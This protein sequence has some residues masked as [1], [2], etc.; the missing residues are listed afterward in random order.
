MSYG[1]GG[2][3]GRGQ[4]LGHTFRQ[5][6]SRRKGLNGHGV[7][8]ESGTYIPHGEGLHR[9]NPFPEDTL[10]RPVCVECQDRI[11]Y[12]NGVWW[13]AE[14]ENDRHHEAEPKEHP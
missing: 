9:N 4:E 6:R 8:G 7:V 14:L 1:E 12:E 11:Y 10:P 13:H 5:R 3:P 2:F